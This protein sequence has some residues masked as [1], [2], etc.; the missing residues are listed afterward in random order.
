MRSATRVIGKMARLS[1][2]TIRCTCSPRS[3]A[4]GGSSAVRASAPERVP[5]EIVTGLSCL[6]SLRENVGEAVG[7]N[8]FRRYDHVDRLAKSGDLAALGFKMSEDLLLD[9]LAR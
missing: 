1:A 6:G 2:S 9:F 5:K 4:T 7:I 8:R 3:T